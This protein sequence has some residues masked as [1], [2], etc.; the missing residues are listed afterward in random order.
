M[1][2]AS[3]VTVGRVTR[4]WRAS[5]RSP[6]ARPDR[7]N[8]VAERSPGVSSVPAQPPRRRSGRSGP[9]AARFSGGAA[10]RDATFTAA[11]MLE[12]MLV[13]ALAFWAYCFAVVFV[14]VRHVILE[15]ERGAAWTRASIR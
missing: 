4:A 15:R 9:I 12:G 11:I 7:S 10:N 6:S 1:A 5:R 3:P 14:R 2:M 13:M 8:K